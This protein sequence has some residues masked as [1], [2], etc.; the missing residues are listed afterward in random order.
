MTLDS[1]VSLLVLGALLDILQPHI[2][3]TTLDTL[4]DKLHSDDDRNWL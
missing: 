4:P 2:T 3:V 1:E